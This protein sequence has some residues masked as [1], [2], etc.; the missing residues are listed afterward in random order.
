MPYTVSMRVVK[1]RISSSN[2]SIPSRNS[3]PWLLPIQFSCISRTLAGQL[4]SPFSASSNSS[5]NALILKN[6]W[7]SSRRSTSAPY[8]Q[9]LPSISGSLASTVMST[10]SQFTTAFRR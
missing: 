5:E 3:T 8:L 6:H 10:G 9:P 1:A 7:L 2:P 4:S